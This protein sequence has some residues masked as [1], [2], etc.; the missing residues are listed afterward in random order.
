MDNKLEVVPVTVDLYTL[1][2]LAHGVMI[3]KNEFIEAVI[4]ASVQLVRCRDL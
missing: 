1:N 4:T 2:E 3:K